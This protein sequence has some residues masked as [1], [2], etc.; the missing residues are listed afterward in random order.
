MRFRDEH[1]AKAEVRIRESRVLPK[2]IAPGRPAIRFAEVVTA[3]AND[4]PSDWIGSGPL[5]I[6]RRPTG[7][8]TEPI[9]APL[10]DI[11]FDVVQSPW[12]GKLLPNG[13]NC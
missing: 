7:Q 8:R 11:P 1:H 10:P 4:F 2:E 3:P 9:L 5:W 13:V 6:N 12:I